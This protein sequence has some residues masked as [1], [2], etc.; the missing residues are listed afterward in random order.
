MKELGEHF[1]GLEVERTKDRIFLC[2]QKYARDLLEKYGMVDCKPMST[3]MEVNAR[4]CSV[5]GKDLED[6]TMYRQLVGSLIYLTLSRPDI[7][8]VVSAISRFMQKPM[9]RHLEAVRRILRYVKGTIYYGILYRNDKEFE[10]VGYCDADYAG[11]LDTRRSTTG[12]VFNLGSGA[13]S[14]CSKRQPTVSLSST[15][16]EYRVAA[17]ETQECVWLMQLLKD[18]HQPIDRGIKLCCDNQSAIRLAENP[19]FHAKT[20]HV[21]VHYHFVREKYLWGEIELEQ[22]NT[23]DQVAD[24]FTKGLRGPTFEKFQKQLGIMSRLTLRK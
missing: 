8:Y 5:E 15:E 12:Y 23:E 11:D 19:V 16:A 1:L 7:A 18:L 13:V 9:K 22:V 6:V 14:W 4:L 21:E 2:Q 20:K 24:I 3:P 17:M 10:V